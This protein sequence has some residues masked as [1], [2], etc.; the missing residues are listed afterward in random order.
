MIDYAKQLRE[1]ITALRQSKGISESRMSR[2]LGQSK[3]YLQQISSGKTLPSMGAFFKICD[4]LEADP[5]EFF[6]DE[7]LD[8]A[9]V[10]ELRNYIKAMTKEDAAFLLDTAKYLCSRKHK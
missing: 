9:Y 7:K 5:I 2:E 6:W 3:C 1:R 10:H 4:Y 8:E